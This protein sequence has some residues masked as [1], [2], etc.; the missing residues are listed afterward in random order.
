MILRKY[1]TN[2]IIYKI[3]QYEYDRYLHIY[4]K[5][6]N[7]LYDQQEYLLVIELMGKYANVIL[8]DQKTNKI[9]DAYKKVSPIETHLLYINKKV[10]S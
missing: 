5:N 3:E 4:I 9:I 7:E 8:V 6:L 2:G 1:L 10:D